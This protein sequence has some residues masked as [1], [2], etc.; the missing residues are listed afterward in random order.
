MLD[1]AGIPTRVEGF[2]LNEGSAV[3]GLTGY[4]RAGI[5]WKQSIHS[6]EVF[7]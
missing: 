4:W 5:P 7:P 1:E 2:I 6:Q 3:L